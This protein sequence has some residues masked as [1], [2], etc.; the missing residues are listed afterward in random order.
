MRVGRSTSGLSLASRKPLGLREKAV[1]DLRS[2]AFPVNESFVT[3]R[4]MMCLRSLKIALFEKIWTFYPRK[5]QLVNI[6]YGFGI[7]IKIKVFYILH[8]KNKWGYCTLTT[9]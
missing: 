7:V 8:C 5:E 9:F 3:G 2:T 1:L 6:L 4:K